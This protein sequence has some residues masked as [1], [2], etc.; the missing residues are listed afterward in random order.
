[1]I[2]EGTKE[3]IVQ[4]IREVNELIEIGIK[5]KTGGLDKLLANKHQWEEQ[6]ANMEK[7]A[8]VTE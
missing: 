1:M 3:Q 7:N 6:L 5:Y 4:A 2:L 8:S